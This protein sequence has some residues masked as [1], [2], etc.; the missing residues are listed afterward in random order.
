MQA[1]ALA[2]CDDEAGALAALADALTLAA[3]EGYVRVFVDDGPPMAALFARLMTARSAR[4]VA[5]WRRSRGLPWPAS[6]G[7]ASGWRLPSRAVRIAARVA[8]GPA[9]PLTDRE[10]E[11][12]TLLAT[13]TSNRQIAD[14]LVVTVDMVKSTSPTSSTS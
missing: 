5:R 10:F 7:L 9:E 4:G 11:V 1:L 8:P 12:L 14:E 3:P 13:G 2:A 6:G